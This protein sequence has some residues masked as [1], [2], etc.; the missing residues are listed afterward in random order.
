MDVGVD[1]ATAPV[2]TAVADA[3]VDSAVAPDAEVAGACPTAVISILEGDEVLTGTVLHLSAERSTA[4]GSTIA[5]YAWTVV[6]PEGSSPVLIP[7]ASDSRPLVDVSLAGEYRVT[8][9]VWNDEGVESCEAAEA[10]VVVREPDALRIELSWTSP[11]IPD[12]GAATGPDLDLH[13]AHPYASGSYDGDHDGVGDGWF[14]TTWDC[15][16][17]NDHPNWGSIDAAADDDPR[18]VGGRGGGGPEALVMRHGEDGTCYR[19][20]VHDSTDHGLGPS[21][22]TVRVYDRGQLA[23]AA[24]HVKLER[25]DLWEV[26]SIC[27]PLAEHPLVEPT[28]RT[29][30]HG[31]ANPFFQ[32]PDD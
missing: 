24:E 28:E 17:F 5:A 14:D 26:G 27:W 21:F 23:F 31:Y 32:S 30:L 22:A 13:F 3:A 20:A 4:P 6:G 2:D 11:G 19:V 16:W 10:R 7:S 8:L 25:L 9:R 1:A 15:F 18:L 29:I 12:G